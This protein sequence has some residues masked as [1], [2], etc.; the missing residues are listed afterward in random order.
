MNACCSPVKRIPPKKIPVT[1]RA[2]GTSLQGQSISNSV[3][4]Q[5]SGDK[6]Q[7]VKVLENG[8]YIQTQSGIT[9]LRLN[10]ILKPYLVKFGSNPASINA[11]LIGRILA[12]NSSGIR[13]CIHANSYGTITSARIIFNDGTLL[14]TSDESSLQNFK[15][16][17]S[18]LLNTIEA[19]KLKIRSNT[20]H[21]QFKKEKYRI[22][23]TTGYGL[24][25]SIDFDD[26]ID[27]ILHL[28]VGSE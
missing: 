9:G 11:A 19:L 20:D 28:M 26:S 6:W 13:C 4:M 22:K 21:V 17:R 15:Q 27:I 25:S 8:K 10:Q 14:D 3:L 2:A 7:E 24:N 12:N 1:F 23:N 18:D 16:T 5:I